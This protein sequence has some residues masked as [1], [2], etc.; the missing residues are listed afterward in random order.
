[1][2]EQEPKNG[3]YTQQL[4]GVSYV[5]AGLGYAFFVD[6]VR[7][8]ASDVQDVKDVVANLDKQLGDTRET[9]RNQNQR[10]VAFQRKVREE[11]DEAVSDGD[12]EKS[13]ANRILNELGLDPLTSEYEVGV[14]V[15]ATLLVESGLNEDDLADAIAQAGVELEF[16]DAGTDF[17]LED[18]RF[19]D[20]LVNTVEESE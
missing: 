6:D 2:T 13:S 5:R 17:S 19:V 11:L 16:G 9:I 18:A 12:I 4:D 3:I 20:I 10:Y 7:M 15:N 8:T 14:T 1:M